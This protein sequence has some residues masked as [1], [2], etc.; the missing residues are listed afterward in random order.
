MKFSFGDPVT[1]PT[2][3]ECMFIAEVINESG[4]VI[5]AQV[6]AYVLASDQSLTNARQVN[7]I[8]KLADLHPGTKRSL[9]LDKTHA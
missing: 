9:S 7:P 4:E 6:A 2:Y 1:H 8:V 3:G 5:G